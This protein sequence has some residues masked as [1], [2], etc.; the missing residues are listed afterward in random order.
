MYDLLLFA[1]QAK[2]GPWGGVMGGA[3]RGALIGGAIGAVVGIVMYFIKKNK[4]DE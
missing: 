3:L 1:Q 4:K 2:D